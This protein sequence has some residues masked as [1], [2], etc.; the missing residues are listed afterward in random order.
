MNAITVS[1]QVAAPRQQVW[2]VIT[3]LDRA[4]QVMPAIQ[5]V[6]RLEGDGFDVGTRWRETR[7]MFGRDATETMQVTAVDAPNSYVVEADGRDAHYRTEFYLVDDAGGTRV[8]MTF[9]A[10]PHGVASRV[11]AATVGR[12]FSGATRRALAADLDDI[13]RTC[14]A[15]AQ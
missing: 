4:P 12:V 14:E 8:T 10:E 9:A 3:D 7:R 13:V 15:E 11:M 6:E 2:D 5:K 1:R